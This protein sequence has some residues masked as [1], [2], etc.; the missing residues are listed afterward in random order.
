M[1]SSAESIGHVPYATDIEN[2]Q[3]RV[4]LSLLFFV[5]PIDGLLRDA[6]ESLV[7]SVKDKDCYLFN[8]LLIMIFAICNKL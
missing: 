5:F 8:I 2:E 6:N 3:R 4:I 1:R 7:F